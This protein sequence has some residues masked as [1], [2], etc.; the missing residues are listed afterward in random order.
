MIKY[1]VD[2][3]KGIFRT[4]EYVGR[5]EFGPTGEIQAVPGGRWITRPMTEADYAAHLAESG[6]R[7]HVAVETVPGQVRA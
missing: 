4:L 5:L 1:L 3:A 2:E 7:R 6:H